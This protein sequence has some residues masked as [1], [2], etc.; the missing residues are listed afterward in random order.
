MVYCSINWMM[1]GFQKCIHQV[2]ALAGRQTAPLNAHSIIP[3]R[4]CCTPVP[5]LE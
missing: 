3:S 1:C 5:L 2:L 4:P